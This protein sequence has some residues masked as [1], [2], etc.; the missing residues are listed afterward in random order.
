MSRINKNHQERRTEIMQT[1]SSLF[2]KSGYQNTS[3]NLIIETLGIS[4]GAFYHYFKSKEQL[5]DALV[6]L[7]VDEVLAVVQPIVE[8]QDIDAIT[9]FNLF[10]KTGGLYKVDNLDRIRVLLKAIY[11]SNNI[12]L[13]HK[14]NERSLKITL[15]FLKSIFEQG[16]QENSFQ[17]DDPESVAR[18]ILQMA[19]SISEYNAN[20]ILEMREKP[21]N[22][23]LLKTSFHTY[24]LAVSRILGIEDGLLHIYNSEFLNKLAGI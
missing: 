4:K 21:D 8:R 13:R 7:F 17:I 18:L 11:D 22:L 10:Y 3:V 14:L 15:P 6:E 23:E 5:L 1:A 24:Q 2:Q 9:K 20:L 12:L 16:K 19:T